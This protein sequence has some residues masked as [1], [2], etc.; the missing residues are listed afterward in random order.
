MMPAA[1]GAVARAVALNASIQ[2]MQLQN[3]QQCGRYPRHVMTDT[4]NYLMGGALFI[5]AA[6]LAGTIVGM[7]RHAWKEWRNS[8]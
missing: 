7:A 8:K 4:E 1:A 2:T 3:A 5:A 6:L